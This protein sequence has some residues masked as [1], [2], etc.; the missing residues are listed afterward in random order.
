ME[1][2]DN[3]CTPSLSLIFEW[4]QFRRRQ[5]TTGE[6]MEKYISTFTQ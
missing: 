2:F 3:Y 6:P 1:K 4:A 5:Q